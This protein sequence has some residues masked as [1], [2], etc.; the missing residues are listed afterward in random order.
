MLRAL[1][2]TLVA[3]LLMGGVAVAGEW[4]VGLNAG[5]HSISANV[6]HKTYMHNGYF[7]VGGAGV[8]ADDDPK[9]YKWGS[10][11]FLVGSDMLQPG[12]NVEIGLRGLL[13]SAEN[14]NVSGDFGAV[15][16]TGG[17]GYYFSPQ[18]MP[19]PVELFSSVTWAPSPLCFKDADRYL[20]FNVG[21]GLRIISTASIRISYTAHRVEMK[22]G[23][24]DWELKDDAIR[25]GIVMR[26]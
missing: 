3:L 22:S 19:I 18:V 14:R 8:Y 15:A 13:G 12:L 6:H 16:F 4:E 24:G 9:E 26:F 23:P 2:L 7:R 17:V 10:I 25:L 1:I 5:A 11:D 21:A 20:E